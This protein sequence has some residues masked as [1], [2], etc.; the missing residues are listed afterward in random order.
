MSHD[1]IAGENAGF[2]AFKLNP[3]ILQTLQ[4]VG[5]TEPSPIQARTIPLL[6]DGHDVLGLAQT[7]TGK[8]A[9]FALPILQHW[10]ADLD[11][12]QALVL[13]PTRELAI[14]VAEAFKRYAQNLPGF[15][16]C[17]IYGGQDMRTQ[18]RALRQGVHVV[19]A[20]PGRLM[21]HL[22][23][24]SVDLSQVNRVVLDEADEMLRMGFQEDVQWILEHLPEERQTAL[25]SATMP[26]G[27]R[28]IA[29]N[30]LNQP[31][32]VEI[33]R[34]ER[35]A[36]HIEQHY[37]VI[38]R[39]WDKMQVL[40]RLLEM[41]GVDAAIIFVRTRGATTEVA[42][43]LEQMGYR[44]AAING[45]MNQTQRERSIDA[46]KEGRLD[47][48]V[49]TD[50]AAR[51]IDVSRISHVFNFDPPHDQESYIH[52][53]GRTGRAGRSGQ[54]I[55]FVTPRERHLLRG[56]E[57]VT[58]K[59]MTPL[60]LPG[61]E[62]LAQYR[63]NNLIDQ[64]AADL[65]QVEDMD[66]F[67]GVVREICQRH[68]ISPEEA[69]AALCC[70]LQLNKPLQM[71]GREAFIPSAGFEDE[72]RGR[73]GKGKPNA[74]QGGP[75][76]SG[77]RGRRGQDGVA[78]VRY[79]VEV[80]QEHQVR[81]SDLVGA[82]ANEGGIHPDYI[83]A[84][85][86]RDQYSLIEMP[87]EMPQDVFHGLSKLWVRNRPLKIRV[88]QGPPGGGGGGRRSGPDDRSDR[89]KRFE[90]RPQEGNRRPEQ[91]PREE[92]GFATKAP[93]KPSF[94]KGKKAGA[95]APRKKAHFD[96]DAPLRKVAGGAY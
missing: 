23:R 40:S 34:K 45:D 42:Q 19:V 21:D 9:A 22:R 75:R 15:K 79:R 31:E 94:G 71:K 93:R 10:R 47:L 41:G 18:L 69:A 73:K 88:D 60:T 2:G 74:A 83:G 61:Q 59:A 78:L 48:L 50:V 49:A 12:P 89:N 87:A 63:R 33:A 64:V 16:V 38:P 20:T 7:G 95:Q 84:I 66:F 53:I 8:T 57:R 58:R 77:P 29:E 85:Q 28:R 52:R 26:D 55:L 3:A 36:E 68:Q 37:C 35:T 62:Q 39:G 51:G 91:G 32:R 30:H 43:Q 24:N 86:I 92:G 54:A 81:P 25:F 6:L 11:R 70:R 76:P 44:A 72:Q 96:A 56:I 67:R 82:I 13:A 27:V 65:G 90:G 17:A 1:Q 80:G 5:Y 46:L 14:Q 4:D